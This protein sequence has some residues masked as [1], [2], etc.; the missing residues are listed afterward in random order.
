MEGIRE[1][2]GVAAVELGRVLSQLFGVVVRSVAHI[3]KLAKSPNSKETT[4]SWIGRN[5]IAGKRWALWA[6]KEV[7]SVFGAGHCRRAAARS[8][9]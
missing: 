6:E 2:V 8:G 4:S 1:R 3:A 7:D 9:L 5:A